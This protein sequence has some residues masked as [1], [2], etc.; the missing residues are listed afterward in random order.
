MAK[1]K[2]SL[3]LYGSALWFVA[4]RSFAIAPGLAILQLVDSLISAGLPIATTYF[5]ALTTTALTEA[6]S[7]EAGAAD[8]AITYVIITALLG[9]V[10]LTWYSIGSFIGTKGRYKIDVA[11][12]SEM[13]YQFT[14]LPFASYDSKE[15]V[16]MHDKAQRFSRI[17]SNIFTRLS[18]MLTSVIGAIGSIIALITVSPSLA[19]IVFVSVIPSVFIN[20][21]LART[22][23]EHW[24]TNIT[25]RRRMWEIEWTLKR[26]EIMAE[27]RVYGVI[28]TLITLYLRY[29]ETDEKKRME[30]DLRAGWRQLGANILESIV[31]L[32]A[33]IW[34]V[35]QI[36][37]RSQPVGQFLFVQQ[38]VGRAMGNVRSFATQL[39]TIDDEFAHMIDY[40]R[41]MEIETMQDSGEKVQVVPEII[42]F[43]KVFFRYP[44]SKQY[45]LRG[46][47]FDIARGTKVA[48]V[49]EN[50]AGKSTVI[51]LLLGLYV[52]TK[53]TI[54]LDDQPLQNVSITS[55]HK[56]IG[57]LWQQFVTYHYGTIRENIELGDVNKKVSS[58]SL[59]S[60]MKQA[61]FHSVA[62]KLE[63]GI[64]TYIDKWMGRDNDDA[65]ATEL[66]GGQYQR[67]ALARNFFRDAPII[68]L[69]EPTSAIDA[70]AETRIFNRILSEKDKTII[71]ISHRFSTIQKMDIIYMLK[72][73]RIVESGTAEELIAKKGEFYKMFESQ[74]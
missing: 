27:M 35:F 10:A 7:G 36:I 45:V 11:I 54:L 46:I 4:K 41:F 21:K 28:R 39:G 23:T 43:R 18:E 61:E 5:A 57:L 66:S 60:A 38:M 59:T 40:Q 48:F 62:A 25:N 47:D 49:G 64:D 67:L 52:P 13:M 53:G 24:E 42:S 2:V 73:G 58:R 74:I 3:R 16:D 69:D 29:R 37:D 14:Q 33:L 68:I 9:I 32:G 19:L 8:R 44:H 50:G 6:Y 1:K 30:I 20:I 65:S 70:L 55:W 17:F 51:K 56:K 26:P 34:V 15:M 12:E 72:D 22:Q 31:E 71:T 63:R